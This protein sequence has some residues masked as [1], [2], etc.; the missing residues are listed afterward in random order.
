M[1]SRPLPGEGFQHTVALS[2]TDRPPV[3]FVDS[4]VGLD[5]LEAGWRFPL[6]EVAEETPRGFTVLVSVFGESPEPSAQERADLEGC[7]AE[8]L[9]ADRQ[10]TQRAS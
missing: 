5:N 10:A 2:L 9:W 4:V 8:L 7:V 3:A 1:E 6:V